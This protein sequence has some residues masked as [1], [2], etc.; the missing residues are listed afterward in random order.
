M[1]RRHQQFRVGLIVI[2]AIVLFVSLLFFIVGSSLR[3]ERAVY[4]IQFRE[5][6]KGMVIG[7][8]ANYMG[9]PVGMVSDIR[10]VNGV[11]EVELT[12]DPSK[13]QIQEV[14]R[15]R[16]D[17]LLV[18]G[19]VTV[20]LEGYDVDAKA[21][22]AGAF[23]G[24]LANPIAELTMNL[25]GVVA[26]ADGVLVS[27]QAV[28]ARMELVL[29]DGNVGR[30][31]RTLT[32]LEAAAATLPQHADDMVLRWTE[33]AEQVGPLLT[34]AREAVG[35]IDGAAESLGAAVDPEQIAA[36]LEAA[37][38]ALHRLEAGEAAFVALADS[39]RRAVGGNS[40]ELRRALLTFRD[41]VAEI[42]GL[43]R[44]LRIAPSSLVFGESPQEI[45]VPATAL[46]GR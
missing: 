11:T 10:F 22:P 14:T 6:V 46:P 15:A 5:N 45:V 12:V 1:R 30:I 24:S 43:A 40:P 23:I 41:A 4:Y 38:S 39:L 20:E 32:G 42:Q 37:R 3:S 19:Q 17:R 25:P 27:L 28:L 13:A 2:G 31:E 34:A 26:H 21:L 33:A 44:R 8:R 7:S 16:L 35:K 18:T 29:G 36:T 9:V